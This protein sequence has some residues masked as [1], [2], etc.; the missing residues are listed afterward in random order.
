MVKQE[1]EFG[2][3]A[4]IGKRNCLR[5][6]KRPLQGKKRLETTRQIEFRD[7]EE[8]KKRYEGIARWLRRTSPQDDVFQEA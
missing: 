5:L 6:Q 2:L 3:L 1:H 4:G 7:Q 8:E